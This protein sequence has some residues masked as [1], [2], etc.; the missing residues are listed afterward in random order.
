MG[1]FSRIL[2]VAF[3]LLFSCLCRTDGQATGVNGS[4]EFVAV[5]LRRRPLR[6]ATPPLLTTLAAV[7]NPAA[8]LIPLLRHPRAMQ[9]VRTA[10]SDGAVSE[11]STGGEQTTATAVTDL[12]DLPAGPFVDQR[13]R[14]TLG[15]SIRLCGSPGSVTSNSICGR[16]Q[17]GK[18]FG[19]ESESSWG[20]ESFLAGST[21]TERSTWNTLHHGDKLR[22]VVTLDML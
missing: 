22:F 6:V 12:V 18:S 8:P 11:E 7:T 20:W 13:N 5:Y 1:I 19:I 21:V 15:F 14:T 10:V 3:S 16:S 2:T 4:T 17:Q 9:N